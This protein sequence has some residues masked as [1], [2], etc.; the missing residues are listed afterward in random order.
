MGDSLEISCLG[1][2]P[3]AP[4]GHI[5]G[6]AGGQLTYE[7]FDRAVDVFV[8][9]EAGGCG[10]CFPAIR[11]GVGPGADMLGA[12]VPLQVAG[13]REHLGTQT[14]SAGAPVILLLAAGWGLPRHSAPAPS[15]A[16][17]GLCCSGDSPG[18]LRRAVKAPPDS[19]PSTV[20]PERTVAMWP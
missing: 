12:D 3:K 13:V 4:S 15:L 18:G 6:P 10:E 1:L 9:L 20:A 17:T 14:L 7:R 19:V 16:R 11:A 8:L 5:R 2:T